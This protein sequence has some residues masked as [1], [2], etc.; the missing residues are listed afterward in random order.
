[1]YL[2]P[3]PF[4]YAQSVSSSASASERWNLPAEIMQLVEQGCVD[5]VTYN[6]MEHD[7][8]T[9]YTVAYKKTGQKLS[10][11]NL[12]IFTADEN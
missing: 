9:S 4:T 7:M 1:M 12:W 2:E 5:S 3:N 10:L 8:K 11:Y 6:G